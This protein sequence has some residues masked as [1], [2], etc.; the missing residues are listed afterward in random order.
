MRG[1]TLGGP[2]RRLRVGF[3]DVSGQPTPGQPG[4]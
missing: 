3:A 2:E 4:F 1:F